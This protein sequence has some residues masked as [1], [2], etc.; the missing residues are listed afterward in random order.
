MEI[1]INLL[2]TFLE[3]TE[4]LNISH[5]A[6][7]LK[8]S[9]PAV[10][11]QLQALEQ[12]LGVSLFLR[13]SRGLTL[14]IAG[15]QLKSELQEPM[16]IMYNCL[17]M[18]RSNTTVIAGN[19]VMGSLTEVG[20][21]QLMPLL[22]AFAEIHK[23]ISLDIRL[24][25]G[26]LIPQAVK[27]GQ[28][29]LGVIAG[30]P[31]DSSLKVHHLFSE[32]IVALTSSKNRVNLDDHK[33]PQFAANSSQDPLLLSFLSKHFQKILLPSPKIMIS[34]NSHRSMLEA[35]EST[36]LYAVMP[37]QSAE[38]HINKGTL[39]LASKCE[40]KNEVYLVHRKGDF[41]ERRYQELVE[42]LL[43]KTKNLR[44]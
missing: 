2:P 18:L 38:E 14:T 15:N 35:L 22:I 20:K 44:I 9:Q 34:V 10:S 7:K 16:D 29:G 1:P 11:R 4:S 37:I 13:Q 28:L 39:R 19:I 30:K 40:L 12:N 41:L 33:A 31:K 24:M 17:N 23:G 42:F 36:S 25:S 21:R 5:T 26:R 32:R 8:I 6:K 27:D 43:Q 3:L